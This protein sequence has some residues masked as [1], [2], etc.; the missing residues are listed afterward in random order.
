MTAARGSVRRREVRIFG[1]I[2]PA[3]SRKVK[4]QIAR[5]R[6]KSNDPITV[7]ISS[8]GGYV[9]DAQTIMDALRKPNTDGRS[10]YIYTV[11]LKRA[12][13]AAAEILTRGD[14]VACVKGASLLFHGSRVAELDLTAEKAR[15]LEGCLSAA[16][17]D[18]AL[19]VADRMFGRLLYLH[20]RFADQ[21]KRIR[22]KDARL[23]R[24]YNDLLGDGTI[25]LPAFA[26]LL[27]TKVNHRYQSHLFESLEESRKIWNVTKTYHRL[28]RDERS[29]RQFFE[30]VGFPRRGTLQIFKDLQ[31]VTAIIANNLKQSKSWTLQAGD[32]LSIGQE[33]KRLKP[34]VDGFFEEPVLNQ[35]VRYKEQFFPR[36]SLRFVATTTQAK[37][38]RSSKAQ[39]QFDRFTERAYRRAHPLWIFTCALCRRLHQSDNRL[40][41]KNAWWLGL[42]DEAVGTSL[43]REA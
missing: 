12:S 19:G 39:K 24:S 27:I 18:I 7:L 6:R 17:E 23:L 22:S 40:S 14:Y 29:K 38:N 20:S 21:A 37:F 8:D 32:L 42:I 13:S 2:D 31:L 10:P 3:L 9:A 5:L 25:D 15:Q 34:I 4:Q 30:F 35:L 16:N 41:P 26:A 33:V 11:A 28:Q 1:D 43:V 36:T